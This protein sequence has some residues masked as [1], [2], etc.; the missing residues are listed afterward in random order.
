MGGENLAEVVK[1]AAR[2]ERLRARRR[3]VRRQLVALDAE[4]RS[5]RKLLADLTRPFAP[6]RSLVVPCHCGGDAG[7]HEFRDAV[8]CVAGREASS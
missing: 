7:G 3:V 5:A 8:S 1:L 6:A 4:V 2:L